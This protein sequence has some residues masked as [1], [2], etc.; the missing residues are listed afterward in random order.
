MSDSEKIE[1]LEKT[2]AELR[3]L[4]PTPKPP[5]QPPTPFTFGMFCAR[6]GCPYVADGPLNYIF[7]NGA[8]S[9]GQ[10]VHFPVPTDEIERNKLMS[11]Y[12]MV[13]RK[14]IA[15]TEL[16]NLQSQFKQCKN[17]CLSADCTNDSLR[18]LERIRAGVLQRQDELAAIPGKLD[19]LFDR[20]RALTGVV[21]PRKSPEQLADEQAAYREEQQRISAIQAISINTAENPADVLKRI[22]ARQQQLVQ[23][24]N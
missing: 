18:D 15:E 21:I 1:A 22:E 3:A 19:Q 23:G 14:V 17:F 9:D 4:V 12:L 13:R 16:P 11:R 6:Q 5:W 2:V 24:V 20:Y 10:L 8:S 7:E